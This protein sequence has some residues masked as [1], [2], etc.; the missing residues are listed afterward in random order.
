MEI[1]KFERKPFPV[2]AVKVTADNLAEVAKWCGGDVR[3]I[4][5]SKPGE[6]IAYV[7]V[8]ARR[9]LNVKQTQAFIGDW[10]LSHENG[11]KVYTEIA[12]FKNFTPVEELRSENLF[13]THETTIV[14]ESLSEE[15]QLLKD[16]LEDDEPR[17]DYPQLSSFFNG[18]K[19]Q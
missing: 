11:F 3:R 4:A 9:P 13:E 14:D 17:G 18:K 16:I 7:K 2:D 1:I 15:D 8:N 6:T 12:L 19:E 10:V 5:G